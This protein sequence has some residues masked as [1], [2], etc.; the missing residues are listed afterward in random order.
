MTSFH[1]S[2]GHLG[3]LLWRN[4]YLGLCA[5]FSWL[6]SFFKNIEL[7][8][9][10]FWKW[11]ACQSVCRLSFHFVYGFLYCAKACAFEI[12][13]HLFI[14]ALF[15]LPWETDLRKHWYNICQRM[16]YLS[17]LLRV[18]WSQVFK[19]F[20]VYSPVWC[21]E[22][23]CPYWFACHC[24]AFPERLSSL[25]WIFLPPLNDCIFILGE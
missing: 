1:V 2:L 16:F 24:P 21:V 25:H 18:L 5:F 20:G 12:W 17:S 10:I 8:V 6:A 14:F 11:S 3:S 23:F 4:V 7:Y 9:F 22:A 13:S 15:L 19:P